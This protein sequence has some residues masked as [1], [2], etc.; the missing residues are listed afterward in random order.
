MSSALPPAAGRRPRR[1]ALAQRP[2]HRP[3]I[4]LPIVAPT[5]LAPPLDSVSSA[6]AFPRL[7]CPLPSTPL[8]LSLLSSLPLPQRQ[9][10]AGPL[11]KGGTL[12]GIAAQGKAPGLAARGK[13]IPTG[14]WKDDRWV[15]G[16]WDLAQFK[17][18]AGEVSSLLPCTSPRLSRLAP[19]NPPA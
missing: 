13:S 10:K 11:A 18:A 12:S 6:A 9:R 8:P 16:T 19:P 1:R 15:N 2:A 17:D 7:Y 3:S 5:P 14:D 4:L